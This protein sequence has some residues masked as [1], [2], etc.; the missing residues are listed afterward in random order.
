MFDAFKKRRTET[1]P[2][3]AQKG[4]GKRVQ[5]TTKKAECSEKKK[6]SAPLKVKKKKSPQKSTT[7]ADVVKNRKK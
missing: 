2:Q 1:P 7:P 6:C 3:D 5:Q 4:R